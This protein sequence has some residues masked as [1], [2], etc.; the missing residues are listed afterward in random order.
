MGTTFGKKIIPRSIDNSILISGLV[1]I[2]SATIA[3]VIFGEIIPQA[4]CSRHGLEVGARTLVITKIFMVLTFPASY[5]IS[6]VLDY[7]LGEEIGH[8]YDREKLVEYIKLTMDYTQVGYCQVF[9]SQDRFSDSNISVGNSHSFSV[10]E[11]H[12][13][14]CLAISACQ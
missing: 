10:S 14:L 12:Y 1:A 6:L 2:L 7:C 4:I 3:I 11:S 5:P 8:V 9:T 13:Q